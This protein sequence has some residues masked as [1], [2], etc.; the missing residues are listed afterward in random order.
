MAAATRTPVRVLGPRGL[1]DPARPAAAPALA[2]GARPRAGQRHLWRPRAASRPS[3]AR[4]HRRGAATRSSRAARSRRGELDAT[5][6]RAARRPGGAGATASARSNGCSGPASSRPR[7]GAASSASTTCTERVLPADDPGAPT[8]RAGGGAAR[9]GARSRPRALGIA[10]EPRPARLFP[11]RPRRRRGRASPSSSRRASSARRGRGLARAGLS[12]PERRACRAGSR[13]A[14]SSRPSIRSSGSATRTERLF[15]FRYRIEIYTPAH[16]RE[17][18]YY[19]LPFLLGDRIAARL[20]LKADRADRPP[21]R[22][23]GAPRTRHRPRRDP[24]RPRGRT[25]PPRPL[26]RPPGHRPAAGLGRLSPHHASRVLRDATLRAAPQHDEGWGA[27]CCS[28]PTRP[29]HP[30]EP[31]AGGRL[32]GRTTPGPSPHHRS[33]CFET[34]AEGRLLSMTGVGARDARACHPTSSS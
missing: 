25:R 30:E 6:G 17:H 22:P 7:P 5:G 33:A 26:A 9:A 15:G 2:H 13:R 20:D 29:R 4:L 3:G 19:V 32:E 14:R 18:G 10:T 28:L 34:P 24:G 11:P 12:R 31:A 1:A 16:K 21:R 27:R 8:P 23:L